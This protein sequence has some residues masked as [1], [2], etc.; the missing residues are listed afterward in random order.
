MFLQIRTSCS[1]WQIERIH[2]L[3]FLSQPLTKWHQMTIWELKMHKSARAKRTGEKMTTNE[4]CQQNPGNETDGTE[5]CLRREGKANRLGSQNPKKAQEL[6][7]PG[8]TAKWRLSADL[9]EWSD[10]QMPSPTLTGDRTL[11]F[12]RGWVNQALDSDWKGDRHRNRRL[13]ESLQLP[14]PPSHEQ[15]SLK[16]A[17]ENRE[18]KTG[19]KGNTN[20]SMLEFPLRNSQFLT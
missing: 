15:S 12:W 1:T 17:H 10:S 7:T 11:T 8:D 20:T 3:L 18:R 6:E 2:L 4:K 16:Q 14:F 19:P 9:E 5:N 13:S